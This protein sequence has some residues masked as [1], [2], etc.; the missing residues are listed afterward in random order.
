V[1]RNISQLW[2]I[3]MLV[4]KPTV[5]IQNH[6]LGMCTCSMV[7]LSLLD[8]TTNSTMKTEYMAI[9]EADKKGVYIRDFI[10]ELDVIP[11]SL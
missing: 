6:K 5:I 1:V 10:D 2:G 9:C 3:T 7:E 8:N 11:V 4:S